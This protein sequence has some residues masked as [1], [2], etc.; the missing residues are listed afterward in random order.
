MMATMGAVID[1]LMATARSVFTVNS[2]DFGF[3]PCGAHCTD[4]PVPSR[5]LHWDVFLAISILLDANISRE[6]SAGEMSLTLSNPG[7]A[8]PATHSRLPCGLRQGLCTRAPLLVLQNMVMAEHF[9][10]W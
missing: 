2:V 8:V 3:L 1:V 7:S 10:S 4:Y 9:T 5:C 6:L